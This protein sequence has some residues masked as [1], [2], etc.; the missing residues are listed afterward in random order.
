MKSSKKFLGFTLILMF[1]VGIFLPAF[2]PAMLTPGD[3]GGGAPPPPPPPT[4]TLLLIHGKSDQAS[5]WNTLRARQDFIDY[6][7]SANMVAIS[8]YSSRA[9]HP[10]QFNSVTVDTSIRTIGY[11]MKNYIIWAHQQGIIAD[12]LDIVCHSMGGL[13][14]RSMIKDYYP[15]I[16]NAGITIKHYCS[17]ATPHQGV[18][19][20][21]LRELLNFFDDPLVKLLIGENNYQDR[22]MMTGSSFLANL[23]SGEDTPYSRSDATAYSDINWM[24]IRGD[25]WWIVWMWPHGGDGLVYDHEAILKDGNDL[26]QYEYSVVHQFAHRESV[27]LN[28]VIYNLKNL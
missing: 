21:N 28:R 2:A 23:N 8:Y 24:T 12:E 5:T 25:V 14:I 18:N 7:G 22:Q 17:I 4:K 9:D 11:Y 26:L 27:T 20:A 16:K 13:V 19:L 1:T 15:T 3:G 10:S 6:Y